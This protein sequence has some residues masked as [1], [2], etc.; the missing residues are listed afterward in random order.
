[1]PTQQQIQTAIQTGLAK[2]YNK[3]VAAA[4]QPHVHTALCPTPCPEEGK[5][6]TYPAL[7][8]Q[9]GHVLLETAILPNG[10]RAVVD[11]DVSF[12]AT[13]FAS[14]VAPINYASLTTALQTFETAHAG[15]GSTGLQKYLDAWHVEGL[16]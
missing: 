13:V 9:N 16:I 7:T 14:V 2:Y 12:L 15:V 10:A 4:S 3:Q 1:M 6:Y 11:V 8:I 5:V